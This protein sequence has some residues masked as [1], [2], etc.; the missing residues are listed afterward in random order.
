MKVYKLLLLLVLFL[1]GCF[2]SAER[3]SELRQEDRLSGAFDRINNTKLV[4]SY[5][6]KYSTEFDFITNEYNDTTVQFLLGENYPYR[7]ETKLIFLYQSDSLY[8][9]YSET[10]D[11]INT[12]S[13]EFDSISKVLIND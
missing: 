4:R 11:T 3:E 13:Y 7:F 6:K 12:S 10:G 9:I 5:E 1:S 2:S 8:F